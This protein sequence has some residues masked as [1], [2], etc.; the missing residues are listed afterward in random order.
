MSL[1]ELNGL[2]ITQEDAEAFLYKEAEL[3]DDLRLEEWL[4][5]FTAGRA[6]LGPDR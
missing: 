5:L 6:L 4:R 1:A 3:L 2:S